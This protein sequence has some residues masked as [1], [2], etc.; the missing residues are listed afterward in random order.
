MEIAFSFV[1]QARTVTKTA[2]VYQ[3]LGRSSYHLNNVE[4]YTL[5]RPISRATTNE[6]VN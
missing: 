5:G 3:P 1:K 4:E 2:L 6:D